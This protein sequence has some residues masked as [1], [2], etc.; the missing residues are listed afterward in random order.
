MGKSMI[1]PLVQHRSEEDKELFATTKVRGM[2]L[3]ADYKYLEIDLAYNGVSTIFL[4]RI[5]EIM[6]KVSWRIHFNSCIA[7]LSVRHRVIITQTYLLTK[8][9]YQLIH[10]RALNKA[11]QR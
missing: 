7:N 8:I 2:F 5:R 6:H 4:D 1:M 9:N 10:L 11:T 3:T